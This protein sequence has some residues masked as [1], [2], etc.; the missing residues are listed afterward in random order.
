MSIVRHKEQKQTGD[1]TPQLASNFQ[2]KRTPAR[3]ALLK[4]KDVADIMGV[5][6]KTVRAW[7]DSGKL[8]AMRDGRIIRITPAALE[9]Y[10]EE[11]MR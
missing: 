4:V 3:V 5:V 9:D 10:I 1:R 11:H 7:I 2:P 6:P 8:Q